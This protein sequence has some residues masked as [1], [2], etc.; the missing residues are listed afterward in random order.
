M[1][2]TDPR[3]VDPNLQWNEREP[4]LRLAVDQD[5]ARALGLTPQDVAQTLELLVNGATI[6]TIRDGIEKIAVVARASSAERL[7]PA[8]V[9]DLTIT[10]RNGRAV[11]LA[12]IVKIERTSEE[13]LIWRWNRDMELA[14][15]AQTDRWRAASRCD[16]CASREAQADRRCAACRLSHRHRRRRR[17]IGQ[18]QRLDLQALPLDV[19]AHARRA[20]GAAAELLAAVPGVP[21]GTARHHRG[22]ARAQSR[23]PALRLRGAARAHR[24][25]RHDHAQRGDPR[26]S[27]RSRCPLGPPY[28]PRGD[29]RGD[30]APG[31]TRHPHR[32]SR[33]FSP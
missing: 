20:H 23:R 29:R 9:A 8:K 1:M 22:L 11:P 24:A 15:R 5:R 25:C 18:G 2:L 32:A 4:S 17:G 26:R 7:D 33:R 6:T 21:H 13:P 27:D 10:A 3:V 19:R 30:G 14:V 16:Q 31:A 28:A 12:Q